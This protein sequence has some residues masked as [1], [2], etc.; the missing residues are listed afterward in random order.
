MEPI[1]TPLDLPML[2]CTKISCML[3]LVIF[4]IS[5]KAPNKEHCSYCK[6][7][8]TKFNLV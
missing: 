7:L 2:E 8:Y 3:A 6:R 4:E 5:Q 1:E